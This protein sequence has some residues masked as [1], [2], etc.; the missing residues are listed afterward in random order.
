MNILTL[1]LV[2]LAAVVVVAL[3]LAEIFFIPGLG[4]M[5]IFGGLL[6]AGVGFYL[7]WSGQYWLVAIFGVLCVL[8]FVLGFYFMGQRKV[9]SK[10]EL[11]K[12]I[13][14]VAV[15]LPEGVSIGDQGIALSRLALGGRVQVNGM[16]FEATSESGMIDEQSKIYVTRVEKD[17]IFV[18][19][20]ANEG[21]QDAVTK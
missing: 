21:E 15:K 13:D 9:V 12:N 2:L 7:I 17:K 14:G 5:G 18:A 20:V 16:I 6:F 4:L 10:M 11:D 3:I 1:I 19:L 8:L